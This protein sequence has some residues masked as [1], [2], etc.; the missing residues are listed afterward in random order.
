MSIVSEVMI[1]PVNGVSQPV[2]EVSEL[3]NRVSDSVN[4]VSD[5]VN[6]VSKGSE[7]SEAERV[8]GRI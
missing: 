8:R 3:V 4:R 6:G 7:R 5:P 1:K 2:N